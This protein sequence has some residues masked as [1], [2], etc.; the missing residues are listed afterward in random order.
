LN[1]RLLAAVPITSFIF[2]GHLRELKEPDGPPTPRQLAR[3]NYLGA[4]A[5]V[6]PGQLGPITK[7][8]A[9]GALDVLQEPEP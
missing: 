9:A 3:L 4:L 2:E 6:E 8:Q 1:I 5:I 7:G